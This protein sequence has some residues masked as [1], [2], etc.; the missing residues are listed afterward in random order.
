MLIPSYSFV[1]L[2]DETLEQRKGRQI[3]AKEDSVSFS[4]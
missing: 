3:R 4:I 1:L 2:I